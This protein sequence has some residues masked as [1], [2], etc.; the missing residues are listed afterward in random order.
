MIALL[1][2]RLVPSRAGLVSLALVMPLAAF[3]GVFFLYPIFSLLTQSVYSPEMARAFPTTFA[4]LE[5]WDETQLPDE[6]AFAAMVADLRAAEGPALIARGAKRLTDE[7]PGFRPLALKTRQA[8]Q[9]WDAPYRDRMIALDPLWG[10]IDTWW[11][12]KRS[13]SVLTGAYLLSALDMR[14]DRQEGIVP[15]EPSRAVFV[16]VIVR[17]FT[18]SLTVTALCLLLGYPVANQLARLPAG[19]ASI[20][21]FLVLLPLWT[22]LLV[23]SSAWVVVLQTEGLVNNFLQAVGFVDRPLRLIFNR[24]GVIIALTHV[25]LP[26]MILPLYATMKAIPDSLLRAS[27]SL[28]AKPVV[29]FWKVYLPLTTEGILAGSLLCF[30]ISLGYYLTPLLVGGSR[31]QM[32]SYYIANYTNVQINWGMAAALSVILLVITAVLF[33][34][35][36]RFKANLSA[37]VH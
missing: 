29:T 36:S 15:M 20:L 13:G 9:G 37:T 18:I 4:T 23:R 32:I 35:Y 11:Q 7:L 33:S 28:G 12:I 2:R 16:D 25:L 5:R 14:V 17:T 34:I 26:F 21:M 31:D 19:K 22:S 10:D 24:P 30:T 27:G 1:R 6:A 8:A 3:L